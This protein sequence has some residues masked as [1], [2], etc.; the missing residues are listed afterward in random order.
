[1]IC[2]SHVSAPNAGS[3][4]SRF[5]HTNTSSRTVLTA[6]TV[7]P[8]TTAT[9]D[10]IRMTSIARSR[11]AG[12]RSATSAGLGNSA[13]QANLPAREHALLRQNRDH[14]QRGEHADGDRKHGAG[15]FES[16]QLDREP[17]AD[18]RQRQP[19]VGDDEVRGAHLGAAIGWRLLGNRGQAAAEADA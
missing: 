12:V 19:D 1:M 16:P 17:F 11:S 5:P 4:S 15:C 3:D 7:W 10:T 18:H 8:N 13:T 2:S 9:N 14:A 6:I